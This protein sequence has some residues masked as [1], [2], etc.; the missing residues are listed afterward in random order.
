M[1]RMTLREWRW[2]VAQRHAH[3]L[4]DA[5]RMVGRA[6]R[7]RTEWT[8]RH[9]VKW[10][11]RALPAH[12]RTWEVRFSSRVYMLP[13]SLHTLK[14]V[15]VGELMVLPCCMLLDESSTVENSTLRTRWQRG[16]ASRIAGRMPAERPLVF[17]QRSSKTKIPDTI[18]STRTPVP[19]IAHD[20]LRCR[21]MCTEATRTYCTEACEIVNVNVNS[22]CRVH[23]P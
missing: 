9:I 5:P 1:A 23:V 20:A 6:G 16:T 15:C 12:V 8:Q 18:A 17:G 13:V 11:A 21:R 19:V 22:R 10:E 3:Y 4:S 7:E 2:Y 14:G